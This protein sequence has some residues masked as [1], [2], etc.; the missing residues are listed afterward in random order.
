[1]PPAPSSDSKRYGPN[2]G[3]HHGGRIIAH[4]VGYGLIHRPI[5]HDRLVN[6]SQHRLHLTLEG[7][8]ISAGLADE[9]QP[10]GALEEDSGLEDDSHALVVAMHDACRAV[11]LNV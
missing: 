11:S 1:M 3:P 9:R 5:D 6:V 2:C 10:L 4:Q 7:G 8:I